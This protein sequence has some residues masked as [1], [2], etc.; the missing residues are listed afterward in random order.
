MKKSEKLSEAIGNIDEEIIEKADERRTEKESKTGKKARKFPLKIVA[1]IAACLAIVIGVFAIMPRGVSGFALAEAAYPKAEEYPNNEMG[2]NSDKWYAERRARWEIGDLIDSDVSEFYKKTAAEFLSGEENR[3]YSPVNIY[4]ALAMLG[5]TTDGESRQQILD[6]L[7]SENI[8]ELREDAKN[9]WRAN[10]CDDGA[11]T[12][13]LA[14]SIWLDENVSFKQRTVDTLAENYYASSYRGG[15][16][17]D[18][19]NK[20]IQKW[21]NEQTGGLLSDYV[22]D[23]ELDPAT[24]MALYSTVYFR[25]KWSNEFDKSENDTKTFH[26]PSGDVETEFMNKKRNFGTY[27][28]GEDFGAVNLGFSEGGVM[29][30]I[31]PD[32]DKT[33]DDVLSSG[34]Y[35]DLI[36][37]RTDWENPWENSKSIKINLSVPRFDVSSKI[38]LSEG[39]ERLGVTD[40]FDAGKSDFSPLSDDTVFI[41]EANHAAR[42]VIDEEG[43]TAAA[44]TEILYSGGVALPPEDE[45]DFILDRPF[46]FVITSD[47]DQPLFIGTVVNP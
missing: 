42:V 21:L 37:R 40:V 35:L 41:S 46:V 26:A 7:G 24:V 31:L 33:I 36:S 20:A 8:E 3:A 28:A 38:G 12:S 6:L 4:M 47:T 1:P 10:Y 29:W 39:L 18:E 32:E 34:E 23:V 17:S 27:Y 45:M 30:F 43:C 25:A 44:F 22:K 11:V 19:I 9:M 2:Y 13:I 15:L 5:E 14:N 16:G